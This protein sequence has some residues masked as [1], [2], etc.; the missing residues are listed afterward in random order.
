ML[1]HRGSLS[2]HSLIVTES[3]ELYVSGSNSHGQLGIGKRVNQF[4]FVKVDIHVPV[5]SVAA[6]SMHSL[7]VGEGTHYTIS[8]SY[9][10]ANPVV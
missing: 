6:G 10:N 5:V 3:R 9:S 1:S 7:A 2:S 8:N 4:E